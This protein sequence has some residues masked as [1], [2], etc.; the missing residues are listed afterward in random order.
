MWKEEY[1]QDLYNMYKIFLNQVYKFN[2]NIE[3]MNTS[4]LY[5]FH[6]IDI[7]YFETDEFIKKFIKFFYDNN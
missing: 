7:N 5:K 3:K 4:K 1:S 2:N 6:I